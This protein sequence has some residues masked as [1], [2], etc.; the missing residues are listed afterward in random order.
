[1]QPLHFIPPSSPAFCLRIWSR[2]VWVDGKIDTAEELRDRIPPSIA[3]AHVQI[4]LGG[5]LDR[6]F[7]SPQ[8]ISSQLTKKSMD[9]PNQLKSTT[10][11]RSN[12][13]IMIVVSWSVPDWSS[14]GTVG[15]QRGFGVWCKQVGR[16][17]ERAIWGKLSPFEPVR[18]K[19]D[20]LVKPFQVPK[21]R[22]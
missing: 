1:M 3:S 19:L 9:T 16:E 11:S 6:H 18:G 2:Q 12:V 7:N 21:A 4:Q 10:I 20:G 8:K 14:M 22:E 17:D 13:L 15:M 5:L